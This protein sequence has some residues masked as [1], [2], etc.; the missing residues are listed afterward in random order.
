MRTAPASNLLRP[1]A[2]IEGA[3]SNVALGAIPFR[4]FQQAD[5]T[6]LPDYAP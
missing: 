2:E 3:V 6:V 4:N 5:G 1:G